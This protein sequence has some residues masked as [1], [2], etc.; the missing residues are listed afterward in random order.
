MPPGG[1]QPGFPRVRNRA[2]D[3]SHGRAKYC[4]QGWERGDFSGAGIVD[5][6]FTTCRHVSHSTTSMLDLPS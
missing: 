2:S 3:S 4:P 1:V 5:D 6:R